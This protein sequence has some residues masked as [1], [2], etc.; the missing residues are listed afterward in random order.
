[1]NETF[2]LCAGGDLRQ[3]QMCSELCKLGRVYSC[4]IDSKE[5]VTSLLKPK[6]IPEKPDVLVLPMLGE[7]MELTLG[8]EIYSLESLAALVKAQGLVLG[9]RISTKQRTLFESMGLSV[10]DYFLRESLVVKNCLPTAEGA[11]QIALNETA[12]TVFGSRL[13]VLG[14]G[15]TAKC[16]ARL[17]KAVG[18]DC[19]VAARRSDALASAWTEGMGTL[20][21]DILA[22]AVGDFNIIINTVPA[23]L[24]TEEILSR[25]KPDCLIIDLAS[26]PGGTDFAAAKRLGLHAVHALAL[27]GKTAPTTAGRLIAQTIEEIINERGKNPSGDR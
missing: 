25:V 27:P 18:A 5:C 22:N 2:F 12:E 26:K 14:F 16:C 9:G 6:D 15:R 24:L 3:V 8:G 11:L 23:L 7:E 10:E 19:T 21:L 17:F 13:L 1:M 20:P 4:G